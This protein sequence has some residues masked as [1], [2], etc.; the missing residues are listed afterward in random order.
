MVKEKSLEPRETNKNK[1][2]IVRY[3]LGD[4]AENEQVAIEDRAFED[5]NYLENIVAIEDDLI[6]S[7][8]NGEIPASQRTKFEN[9]FFSSD[10]RRKKVEFAQALATVTAEAASGLQEWPAVTPRREWQ[11]P[12]KGLFS[13]LRLVPAF[14]GA[15]AALLLVIAG[16]WLITHNLRLNSEI[17]RLRS[18]QQQREVERKNLEEQVNKE[19]TRSEEL[20]AELERE[21]QRVS[22]QSSQTLPETAPSTIASLILGPAISRGNN[23][24]SK[25]EITEAIRTARLQVMIDPQDNYPRFQVEIRSPNGQSIFSRNKLNARVTKSTRALFLSVPAAVLKPGRYELALKGVT[26]D[27]RTED[28]AFHYFDVVKK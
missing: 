25:L 7:Y 3:L 15:L 22:E 24:R 9:S 21:Q 16:A 6:D 13:N 17:A 5:H 12:L 8:V 10:R 28:V 4:L 19:R 14:S 26:G 27:G 20:A 23:N 2:L 18:E 1:D 11:N